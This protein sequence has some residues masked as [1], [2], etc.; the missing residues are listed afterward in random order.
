MTPLELDVLAEL[1]IKPLA[2]ARNAPATVQ[3]DAVLAPRRAT[4]APDDALPPAPAAPTH[5]CRPATSHPARG[6]SGACCGERCCP[7]RRCRGWRRWAGPSWTLRCVIVVA[8]VFASSASRRCLASVIPRRT[9]CLSARGPGRKRM[10]VASLLRSCGTLARQ[11]AG[12]HR[13]ATWQAGL[14]RECGQM[15]TA[16]QSHPGR[17]R[18]RSLQA[19]SAA[20]DRV[21]AAAP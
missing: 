9:G 17:Q 7:C 19:L 1:G 21:V 5:A 16:R 12:V 11:H 13:P 10:S 18:N 4:P 6:R 2:A 15:P 14:Y 8:V 3:A 20:P